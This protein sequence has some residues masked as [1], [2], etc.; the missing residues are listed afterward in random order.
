MRSNLTAASRAIALLILAGLLVELYLAGAALF[1]VTTFQP[2][3]TLGVALAIAILLLF[4]VVLATRPSRR[5][6]ALPALLVALTI[7]QVLLPRL[8]TGV[9]AIAA[10]HV[11]NAAVLVALASRIALGGKLAT[12]A[13]FELAT[14]ARSEDY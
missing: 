14:S 2:H 7:V 6:V 3:R 11:V 8:Q 12:P 1:G 10:L 9:P 5:A 4:V 13:R